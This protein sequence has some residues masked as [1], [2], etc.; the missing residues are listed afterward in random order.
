MVPLLGH[1]HGEELA[2]PGDQ[3]VEVLSGGVQ[4]RTHRG[5]DLGRQAGQPPSVEAVG[6]SQDVAAAGEVAHCRG[7]TKATG[8]P[9]AFS[10]EIGSACGLLNECLHRL[11]N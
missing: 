4:A 7:L 1:A 6:L 9:A 10:P 8:S 5:L 3:G 2:V 11:P